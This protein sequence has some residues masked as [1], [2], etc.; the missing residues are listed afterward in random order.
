MKKLFSFLCLLMLGA[1]MSAWA[2]VNV[3]PTGS[4]NTPASVSYVKLTKK[5]TAKHWQVD[6]FGSQYSEFR[7]YDL[8]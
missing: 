5:A 2:W 6:F 4:A 7:I 3:N 8:D 1:G